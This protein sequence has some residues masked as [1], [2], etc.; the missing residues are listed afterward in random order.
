MNRFIKLLSVI[1]IMFSLFSI[2]VSVNEYSGWWLNIVFYFGDLMIV[3]V[4]FF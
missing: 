2:G 3:Y 1:F 4:D